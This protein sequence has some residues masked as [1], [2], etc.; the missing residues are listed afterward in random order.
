MSTVSVVAQ[1]E[2]LHDGRPGRTERDRL[3]ILTALIDGPSFDPVLRPDVLEIPHDHPVYRWACRVEGCLH[4][5]QPQTDLC[6]EHCRRWAAQ[7]ARGVG[8]AE[9]L[10]DAEP[11]TRHLRRE[12]AGCRI[13]PDRPEHH[14]QQRLCRWHGHRWYLHR[15]HVGPDADFAAWLAEQSP[16]PGYGPC[17]GTPCEN[18]AESPLG[19]CDPH[20]RAYHRDGCPG[21]ATLPKGWWKRY[22]WLGEPVPVLYDDEEGFRRWCAVR[23]PRP[24]PGRIDLRGLRP[25]ARAEFKWALHIH[26]Q[27]PRPT[28]WELSWV[29]ALVQDCAGQNADS[30]LGLDPDVTATRVGRLTAAIA[31]EIRHELRQ[32][33]FTPTDTKQAGFIETD[34]FGV[35]YP[36][37]ASHFD[38]TGIPQLWLRDMTWDHIAALLRSPR[39]PRSVTALTGIRRAALELG[40][41]LQ[42][43]APDGGQTPGLLHAEHMH[44]F[45]ADQ[46]HRERDGLGSLVMTGRSGRPAIVT[47][48]TRVIVSNAVRKMLRE[49]LDLGTAERIGLSR[50]F[51]I[52]APTAG[53]LTT[54][55]ARRPFPDDVARALADEDNLRLLAA[56]D[57]RDNGMREI[58]ETTVITGRR[59]G[60]VLGLR[61]DCLGHY[62]GLAILWH[63]QTKVGNYDA[64]IRIPEPL[65]DLLA[66]RQRK[67][68]DRF[69]HEHGRAPT[70][71][72]RARLALF[73]STNR[74]PDGTRA[75]SH[76]WFRRGFNAWLESLELGHWVPHQARHTLATNLLRA[77]A[78]LPHIRR[79]LG[80]VSDRMAEH[81]VHLSQSDLDDVLQHVW[82]AGPGTAEPGRLLTSDAAPLTRAQAQA[83]AIDLSRRSTPAEGGFCT[84]QP[85]V[86]GGACPWNLDCHNCDKFVLSGADL[87]YWRRKREQWR[88]LAEAAPD[89]ATADYLQRHFDPTARAIDGLEKALAGLDLLDQALAMDLRKPQ[90]YFARIWSTAFRASDLA[91]AG[92][93]GTCA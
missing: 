78:S 43:D 49:S 73:P 6:I 27:R 7:R 36:D 41:F 44:R 79:Y 92:T 5:R 67:T 66:E 57:P 42:L 23:P 4:T 34:H 8:K 84:F 54:R 46:H 58:W 89:D 86:D 26:G 51:V 72:E 25:L 60:E 76:Q 18:R 64:A 12:E 22:E 40:A 70:H 74:N 93:D 85:V 83:L 37:R 19:L 53:G 81:Y 90:D 2:P 68:L 65:H 10:R 3:E 62:G 52:A 59:I 13:C 17:L 29:R 20:R 32:V 50:E 39:R 31:R 82:V 1:P 33:Y 38:L 75:I 9:F 11:M 28:R 47:A 91:A 63:D 61:W 48:N 21:G 77:G 87:L 14:L 15:R 30:L 45:V 35:R 88:Q 69:L 71:T 80:H 24:R 16:R 56:R 55:V